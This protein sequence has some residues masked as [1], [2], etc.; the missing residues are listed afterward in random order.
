MTAELAEQLLQV[1]ERYLLP[2]ADLRKRHRT[3]PVLERQIDHGGNRK[4]SFGRQ[5]HAPP[6]T[7]IPNKTNIW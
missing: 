6:L 4:T 3:A 7:E 1:R 5:P 2:R